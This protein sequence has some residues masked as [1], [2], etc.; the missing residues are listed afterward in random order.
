MLRVDRIGCDLRLRVEDLKKKFK[1][2][3]ASVITIS[4]IPIKRRCYES[5]NIFCLGRY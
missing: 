5:R 3:D 2:T 1:T 4:D